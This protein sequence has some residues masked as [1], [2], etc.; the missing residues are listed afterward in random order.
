MS[1]SFNLEDQRK[2]ASRCLERLTRI[3]HR[4]PP[5]QVGCPRFCLTAPVKQ[6]HEAKLAGRPEDSRLFPASLLASEANSL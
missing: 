3:I 2:D 4:G 1:C 5:G 6:L